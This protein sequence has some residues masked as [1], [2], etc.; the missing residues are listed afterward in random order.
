MAITDRQQVRKI[1]VHGY[2]D[3]K[4]RTPLTAD[5]V[6]PIGSVSK[7]FTAISLMQL[8]DQGRFD[9]QARVARYLPGFRLNSRFKPVTAHD[10]LS[11]TSGI[12]NY[13]ADLSSS[14][15]ALYALREFEPS[16]PPGSHYWYSDIGFQILGYMLEEITGNPYRTY[17]EQHLLKPLGMSAS[18]SI[19]EDSLRVKLPV[20][21]VKWPYGDGWVE[22]PWFEYAAGDASIAA[23]AADMCAYARLLLNGGDSPGGRLLSAHAFALLTTPVLDGYAYG[24]RVGEKDGDKIIGHSGSIGGFNSHVEAHMRDGFAL[25]LLSNAPLDPDL[26]RWTADTLTAAYRGAPLPL[27]PP[28][29]IQRRGFA[30]YSGLYRGADDQKL[31][32][33]EI[34][35]ALS[36]RQGA[37]AVPLMAMG[38]DSF[39]EPAD[40]PQPYSFIF[41]RATGTGDGPVVGVSLGA[42]WYINANYRG[43]VPPAP[44]NEYATY[45]GHYE[46]HSA[47]GPTVRIFVRA[48]R[49][50][51]LMDG[52]VSSTAATPL[53]PVG[54]AEFRPAEPAYNP[55]RLRFDP[56]IA[57]HAIRLML[58]GTPLYRVDTP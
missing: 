38:N 44:P 47:E 4:T 50:M 17:V 55:E 49:L 10:L 24:L 28:P 32:F 57:N 45:V 52:E 9:P 29:V 39:Q 40:S 37:D 7:S 36:I 19:I 56:V 34:D 12:P 46:N 8:F 16:Y 27:R 51:A 30:E 15:Y 14:R 48:G 18:Y 35:G 22:A 5:S 43:A 42:R 33:K 53:V 1:I 6:F 21:Y 58:S 11:H 2:A 23:T 31:E 26:T 13:R 20:S 25:I 41:G 54:R 3:L